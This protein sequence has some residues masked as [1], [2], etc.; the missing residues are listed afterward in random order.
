MDTLLCLP[1]WFFLSA[2]FFV[3]M[4]GL[5]QAKPMEPFFKPGLIRVLILS[6][7]NNHDWRATTPFLRQLLLETGKFDVRVEEEPMGITAETLAPFDVI[8]NDYCGLRL[9]A[10]TEK[11]IETFVKSGKG[12]V[13]IHGAMYGFT[14]QEVLKDHH[15]GIGLKE[16]VWE[17]YI[18]MAGISWAGPP[19]NAYHAPYH[20][21]KIK[22]TQPLHP[23]V[24]GM[25]NPFVAT[26]ELY[27]GMT[28]QPG[29]N[30][31][32]TAYDDPSNGGSGKD[33]PMLVTN[34]YGQGRSFYVA[35]GHELASMREPGFMLSLVRGTEWAA[36]G[37]VSIPANFKF[38]QTNPDALRVMVVTG[39]HDYQSSFYSIFEG[40]KDFTWTHVTSNQ[41]AFRQDFRN[42]FDVLVLYDFS[43]E[44][45]ESGRRNLRAFLE[46]GKGVVVLHHAIADY[47]N[48]PWWYK[49]VVGGRYL[50]TPDLN[51]P[52][53]TYKHDE[54]LFVRPAVQHPILRGIDPMHIWDETYKGMWISPEAKVLLKTDNPTSDG[55]VA[56]ISPY[57]KSKVVYIQLGH[58]SLAYAHP[59]FKLL[60]HNAIRWSGGRMQ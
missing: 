50:L 19:A 39:G 13:I 33:E 16:P 42:D 56:W 4:V 38:F 20:F 22:L 48:W 54:E 43:Q 36:M 34:Q 28:L 60:I 9:G 10:V 47:Q 7:H 11:A 23:I 25:P 46:S 6:G 32:A 44:L 53:S 2:L 31:I 12:M 24:M 37:Q 8:V 29:A 1:K 21:F 55:P 45:D 57:A 51:M 41:T 14:G 49:E 26:D 58:D 18:K 30:V 40:A 52:A 3:G 35:F 5:A 59:S 17:E 15:V 27:H